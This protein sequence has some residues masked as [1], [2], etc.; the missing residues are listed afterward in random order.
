MFKILLVYLFF[1]GTS[2]A[3]LDP[4][5]GSFILQMLIAGLLSVVFTVKLYWY[6]FKTWVKCIIHKGER[7][8]EPPPEESTHIKKSVENNE[9]KENNENVEPLNKGNEK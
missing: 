5:T 8:P 4:G 3:Y 7:P 2:H 9:N 1:T 6:K